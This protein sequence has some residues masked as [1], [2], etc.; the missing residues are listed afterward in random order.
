MKPMREMVLVKIQSRDGRLTSGG[1]H[2]PDTSVG[3][4][5]RAEVVRVGSGRVTRKGVTVPPAVSVGDVVMFDPYRVTWHEGMRDMAATPH[6]Q[7][8]QLA[9]IS[10]DAIHG[11]VEL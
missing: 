3:R 9:L 4:E 11:V 2:I 5:D 10:E 8:G 6:A 1:L 7:G